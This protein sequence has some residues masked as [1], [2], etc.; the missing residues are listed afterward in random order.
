[1]GM[2]YLEGTCPKCGEKTREQSNTN[3]NN[4]IKGN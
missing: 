2:S 1:M 4:I 3:S